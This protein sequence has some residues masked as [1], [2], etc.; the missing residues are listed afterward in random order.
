M[1]EVVT[2]GPVKEEYAVVS[3]FK[4]ETVMVEV[5]IEDPSRE[6]KRA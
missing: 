1:V 6:E 4:E 5:V 2:R 3:A